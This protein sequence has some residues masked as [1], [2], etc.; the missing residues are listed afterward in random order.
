MTAVR[1]SSNADAPVH[2][3]DVR[4]HNCPIPILK[5]RKRLAALAEGALLRVQANDPA[6][7][8]DMAHFCAEA[9]HDLIDTAEEGHEIVFLIR[10]KGA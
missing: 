10:K 1:G 2:R 3:L 5:T 4:G 8:I 7:R 9:G 6:A